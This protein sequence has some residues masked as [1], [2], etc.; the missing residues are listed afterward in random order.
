M[1]EP[2]LNRVL[3]QTASDLS[4]AESLALLTNKPLRAKAQIS[5]KL[6]DKD[7]EIWNNL[8]AESNYTNSELIRRAIRCYA[9]S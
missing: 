5:V 7:A 3:N 8:I 4:R 1:I 9:K 2:N 6:T